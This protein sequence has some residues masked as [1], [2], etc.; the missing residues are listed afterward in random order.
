M[1]R[2]AAPERDAST[3]TRVFLYFGPLTLFFYLALPHGYLL[4]FAT[5]YMLK[6]RLHASADQVAFFRLVTA[7]PVYLSVLFGF[8]RDVWS[9]FG[10]PSSR[11]RRWCRWR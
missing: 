7:L 3:G 9:P 10:G 1:I 2:A 8:V 6:D 5:A 11:C 4:D